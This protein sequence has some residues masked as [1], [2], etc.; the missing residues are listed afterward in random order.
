MAVACDVPMHAM[1]RL[2]VFLKATAVLAQRCVEFSSM[3]SPAAR[4]ANLAAF[5]S[6][7]A[8]ARLEHTLSTARC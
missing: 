4:A 5:R 8:Q 6:G 7:S 2:H 1:R 3:V